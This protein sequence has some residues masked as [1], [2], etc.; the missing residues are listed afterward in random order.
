MKV[1]I[2]PLL[3]LAIPLTAQ[4]QIVPGEGK[5]SVTVNGKPFTDF[6][7]GGDAVKPYLHPLRAASGTIVTRG[8]PM[9][10]DVPGES[11]DHP[12]HRGLWFTHGDVNGY[13]FWANEPSQKSPKKGIIAT[14][15]IEA[16]PGKHK[17]GV[18]VAGPAR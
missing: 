3:A 2:L 5:Y 8:Y 1:A 15:K 16:K 7:F 13:D 12:H 4:V 9:R 11:K 14:K 18:R 17:R 10:E 6:Y